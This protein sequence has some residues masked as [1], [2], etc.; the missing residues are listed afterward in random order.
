[1]NLA[2]KIT[3]TRIILT[4]V[5]IYLFPKGFIF[6]VVGFFVFTL[7]AISDLLDGWVAKHKNQV[8]DFGKIL[9]PIADKILVLSAFLIFLQM[10]LIDAWMVIV[11]ISRE[12]TITGLRLFALSKGKVLAAEKAGK[13]KT[14]SQMVSIFMIMGFVILKEYFNKINFWNEVG[15]KFY[16]SSIYM[17][18]LVTVS[19]TLISGISY[20][21]R[22]R[23]MLV[24][25][26]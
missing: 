24:K 4:F 10:Q 26:S 11:I 6:K 3:I 23:R 16:L 19:L 1:M 12:L 20:L 21:W 18:M 22:N 15:E 9:D 17:V 7:A 5:F 13:H 8:T 25:I 2:N 14:V